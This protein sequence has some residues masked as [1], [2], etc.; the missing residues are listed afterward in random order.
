MT[1]SEPVEISRDLWGLGVSYQGDIQAWNEI[2]N[3]N[4]EADNLKPWDAIAATSEVLGHQQY[5]VPPRTQ[6]LFIVKTSWVHCKSWYHIDFYCHDQRYNIQY[7]SFSA[8]SPSKLIIRFS[9]V[10]FPGISSSL[11]S[12]S[13]VLRITFAV[14]DATP[15]GWSSVYDTIHHR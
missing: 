4:K 11:F 2:S 8:S 7:S 9:N 14:R 15:W 3:A 6:I 1:S 5:I 13:S 12:F 10:S